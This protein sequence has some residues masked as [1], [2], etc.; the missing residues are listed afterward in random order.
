MN[1]RGGLGRAERRVG[2]GGRDSAMG[3]SE[4]R[5]SCFGLDRESLLRKDSVEKV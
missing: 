5:S 3:G 4:D 2:R 1:R